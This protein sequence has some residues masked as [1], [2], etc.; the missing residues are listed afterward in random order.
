MGLAELGAGG[1]FRAL[2]PENGGAEL[3]P[4][5]L[6]LKTSLISCNCLQGKKINSTAKNPNTKRPMPTQATPCARSG[7]G[8]A[9]PHQVPRPFHRNMLL[10]PGDNLCHLRRSLRK[11]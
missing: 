10:K 1:H 9:G 6:L 8:E 4:S 7:G 11:P 3:T 5:Y 2:H